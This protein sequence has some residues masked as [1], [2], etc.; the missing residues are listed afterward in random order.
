MLAGAKE[1]GLNA[2]F[3]ISPSTLIDIAR[4]CTRAGKYVTWNNKKPGNA[5]KR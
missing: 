4:T 3:V 1:R 5:A 2:F